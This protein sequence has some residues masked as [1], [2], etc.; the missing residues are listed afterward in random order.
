V[1]V[2]AEEELLGGGYSA[3]ET[4]LW[5]QFQDLVP[6]FR[7][8]STTKKKRIWTRREGQVEG[9]PTCPKN[10]TDLLLKAHLGEVLRESQ[11]KGAE[12]TEKKRFF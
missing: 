9:P 4:P 2:G 1:R 11:G 7:G 8:K 3:T 10:G 12:R 6:I 5:L